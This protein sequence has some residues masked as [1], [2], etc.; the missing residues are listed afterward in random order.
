MEAEVPSIAAQAQ[1]QA[2]M[3]YKKVH[4]LPARHPRRKMLEEPCR[5]R[6]ERP[7]WRSAAKAIMNRLLD[8]TS[9]RMFAAKGL[10]IFMSSGSKATG[11]ARPKV[12]I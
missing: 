3:V 4:R 1:Q 7:G 12:I 2:V 8:A 5:H 9:S 10:L 6:I 11:L